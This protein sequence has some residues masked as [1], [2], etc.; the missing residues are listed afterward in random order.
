MQSDTTCTGQAILYYAIVTMSM[1]KYDTITHTHTARDCAAACS[2]QDYTRS[3]VRASQDLET[4]G[5]SIVSATGR[6]T[7]ETQ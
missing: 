1:L 2:D 4:W 3:P 6:T 7:L 5:R